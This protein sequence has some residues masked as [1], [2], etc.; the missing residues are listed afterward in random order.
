MS[1][2]A[3]RVAEIK[4][5]YSFR[6]GFQRRGLNPTAV[7]TELA[8]LEATTE[9]ALTPEQVVQAAAH[10]SSPLHAGFTWDDTEAARQHRLSEA[11]RLLRSIEVRYLSR[12]PV[13]VYVHVPNYAS[14][15]EEGNKN[16]GAYLKMVN[17]ATNVDLFSRT[18]AELKGKVASL[19]R[20]VEQLVSLAKTESR[21]IRAREMQRHIARLEKN[22]N[23]TA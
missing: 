21:R 8:R 10:P 5:I 1:K 11:R 9:G 19:S 23:K 13:P 4:P 17:V 18:F 2:A 6:Q 3:T 22:I 7:G 16:Q 20:S 14:D 12:E 15:G